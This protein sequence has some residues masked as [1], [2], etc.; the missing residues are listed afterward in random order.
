MRITPTLLTDNFSELKKFIRK[1]EE[2]CDY[3]QIDI[4]DGK[5]TPSKSIKVSSLSK[6]ETRL[7]ME[8]HLMVNNPIDLLNNFKKIKNIKKII[9]HYEAKDS[10]KEVIEKIRSLKLKVGLAINPETE[11]K[12]IKGILGLVDSVLVLSVNPGFYGSEFIPS[13]LRKIRQIRRIKSNI[14][15]GLDGGIKLNN[16]LKIL[17]YPLDYLCIGSAILKEQDPK[18]AYLEFKRISHAK[19]IF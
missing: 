9:F 12:R 18:K 5:F 3:V 19:S 10:P 14:E 16:I 8:A 2:F 15:I 6:L 1:A 17:K 13:V 4:M 7:N 11:V